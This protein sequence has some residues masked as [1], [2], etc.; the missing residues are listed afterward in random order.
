MTPV[1]WRR[2]AEFANHLP[3]MEMSSQARSLAI[4]ADA[5]VP[6]SVRFLHR[7]RGSLF[8]EVYR[9]QTHGLA[10]FVASEMPVTRF[11]EGIAGL[12][13]A[14]ASTL[15][16]QRQ[17]SLQNIREQRDRMTVMIGLHAGL[18][19]DEARRYLGFARGIGKRNAVTIGHGIKKWDDG[20]AIRRGCFVRGGGANERQKPKRRHAAP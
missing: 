15:V 12:H 5:C 2:I 3:G 4:N 19:L 10:A 9:Q 17:L 11:H 16:V 1:V 8:A 18:D 6:G 20:G 7:Q 14:Y 13:L